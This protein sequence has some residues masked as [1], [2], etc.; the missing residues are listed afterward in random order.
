MIRAINV[1][2][3]K[4]KIMKLLESFSFVKA[5]QISSCKAEVLRNLQDAVEEFN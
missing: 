5:K 3:E 4:M 1:G 2:L